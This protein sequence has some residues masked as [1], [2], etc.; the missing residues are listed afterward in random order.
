M[1]KDQQ[2]SLVDPYHEPG[3]REKDGLFLSW[4]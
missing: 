1:V 2:K 4:G 3:R